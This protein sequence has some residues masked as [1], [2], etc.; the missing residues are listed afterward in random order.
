VSSCFDTRNSLLHYIFVTLFTDTFLCFGALL[1]FTVNS[2]SESGYQDFSTHQIV[3]VPQKI[4]LEINFFSP[5][6]GITESCYDR[7][8]NDWIYIQMNSYSNAKFHRSFA[9]PLLRMPMR[10]PLH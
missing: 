2:G 6:A 5:E 4:P 3:E 9:N 1:Y 10:T 7:I 8:E